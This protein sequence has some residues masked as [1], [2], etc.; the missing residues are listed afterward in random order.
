MIYLKMQ[1]HQDALLGH[2]A[3][4]FL[5]LVFPKLQR[6]LSYVT[7]P[8]FP[9]IAFF[10]NIVGDTRVSKKERERRKEERKKGGEGREKEKE[11]K[12]STWHLVSPPKKR[13][14]SLQTTRKDP[15]LYRKSYGRQ[16]PDLT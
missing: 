5:F 11:N 7:Q 13:L 9:T 16:S 14:L 4:V 10:F 1:S 15:A 12:S 6:D 2:K 8:Q 3:A